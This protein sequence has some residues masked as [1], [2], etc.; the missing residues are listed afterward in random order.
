[1]IGV[2]EDLF[3]SEC[4]INIKK[5][6]TQ[7]FHVHVSEPIL[8]PDHCFVIPKFLIETTTAAYIINTDYR[9]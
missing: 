2:R 9:L 1:M 8:I 7:T 5:F 4:H 6:I 3:Y